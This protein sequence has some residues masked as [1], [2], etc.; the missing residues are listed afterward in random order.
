[1]KTMNELYKALKINTDVLVEK[2]FY[3]K[4]EVQNFISQLKENINIEANKIQDLNQIVFK[5]NNLIIYWDILNVN[6]KMP[7]K[8]DE[9]A[10]FD[11]YSDSAEDIILKPHSLPS[12]PFAL[13]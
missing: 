1:M 3:T 6:A 11:I 5:N 9:D 12:A 13:R 4:E 8:R 7:T 2:T 10:G